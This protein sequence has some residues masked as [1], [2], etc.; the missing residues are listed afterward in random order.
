MHMRSVCCT[1]EHMMSPSHV[2]AGT[3][4]CDLY[5]NGLL[6]WEL[7]SGCAEKVSQESSPAWLTPLSMSCSPGSV[8]VVGPDRGP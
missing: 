6:V 4:R 8:C 2:K 3:L 5:G 1:M 7:F